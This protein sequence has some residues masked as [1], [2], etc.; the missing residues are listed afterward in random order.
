MYDITATICMTSYALHMTSHPL[1]N[2]TPLYVSH[3]VHYIV[4]HIHCICV[5]TPTLSMILQPLYGCI[6]VITP[7]LSMNITATLWMISHPVIMWRPIHY[8][9][10]IL[11]TLYDIKTVCVDYTTLDIYMTSFAIR[12][13]SHPLYHK[14][15]QYLWCHI[16]FRHD[17]KSTV[18]DMTPIVSLSSQT[19][20]WYHTHFCVTSN[21]LCVRHHMHYIKHHIHSLCHHT[22]VLMT[23]QPL[24]MKLNPLCRATYTLYMWHHSH[25][26]VSSHPLYWQHH[27]HSLYDI[28]LGL[29]M[30]FLTLYKTSHP[31][32]MTSNHRF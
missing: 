31:Q 7:T 18:S 20:H 30:A 5:I 29:F 15:P 2:I 12:K 11:L 14:K 22:T 21:P 8:I 26:S 6:C 24:Y 3:Q 17:I 13:T 28:P 16:H 23:S 25:K 27:T 9:Y 32:F 1:F 4:P 19:F 10:Y